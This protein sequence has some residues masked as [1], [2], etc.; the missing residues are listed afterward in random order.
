MACKCTK[1][2]RLKNSSDGSRYFQ[3]SCALRGGFGAGI[4]VTVS[5]RK[6]DGRWLLIKYGLRTN[7]VNDYATPRE[8]GAAGDAWLRYECGR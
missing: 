8:A 5:R 2:L 7:T 6:I 4:K 1:W 3:R